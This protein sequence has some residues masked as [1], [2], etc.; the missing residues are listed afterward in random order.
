[1]TATST[2][3]YTEAQVAD[4]YELVEETIGFRG[5]RV[6]G[7]DERELHVAFSQAVHL[8]GWL[9]DVLESL[10]ADAH[11]LAEPITNVFQ[12]A[13]VV[14][15]M[16]ALITWGLQNQMLGTRGQWGGQGE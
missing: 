15:D 13:T 8:A 7:L 9:D 10:P 12:P 11:H 5:A 1:M 14:L 16:A 4:L 6:T 2:A 3:Y